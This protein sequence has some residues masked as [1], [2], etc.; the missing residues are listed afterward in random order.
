MG[1][2]M[3]TSTTT[4]TLG[5]CLCTGKHGGLRLNAVPAEAFLPGNPGQWKCYTCGS[6]YSMAAPV[7]A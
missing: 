7:V 1:N 5:F 4:Q 6:A 2:T 3:Q